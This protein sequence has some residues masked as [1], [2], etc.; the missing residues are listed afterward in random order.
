MFIIDSKIYTSFYFR[1]NGKLSEYRT[2]SYKSASI[3]N[4]C[5][6]VSKNER[7]IFRAGHVRSGLDREIFSKIRFI[8]MAKSFRKNH[9]IQYKA[10]M[11]DC[12]RRNIH[13]FSII[14]GTRRRDLFCANYKIRLIIM[15]Q[16]NFNL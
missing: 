16:I 7:K 10:H 11:A 3:Y 15:L 14:C 6:R 2:S 4:G 5:P 13:I 8:P 9:F 1:N 12:L